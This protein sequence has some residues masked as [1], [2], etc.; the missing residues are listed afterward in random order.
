MQVSDRREELPGRVACVT[1]AAAPILA[2][3]ERGLE[4]DR[5][6]LY[7][8]PERAVYRAFGFGRG[9]VARVWLHPRVLASYLRLLKA[10]RRTGRATQDTLQLGGDAVIDAAG[11]V[12][13]VY[14]SAGP[15]DRPSVDA[16]VAAAGKGV[17]GT[18]KLAP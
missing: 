7:G 17:S 14:R 11:R 16:L 1:F 5:I 8:D 18:P 4:L 3:F 12:R 10:G 9:S 6:E 13:W 15:D 2:A